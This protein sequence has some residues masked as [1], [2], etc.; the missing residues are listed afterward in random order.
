MKGQGWNGCQ[1]CHM[2][3]LTDNVT[4]FFARGPRQSTSLDGSFS[5]KDPNDQR[6]FNW[7]A[8][9]DEV[10]DFEGN[11]RGISGGVGAV[12]HTKSTPPQATDQIN[13]ATAGHGGLSGSADK[14][15]D[16]AN[17]AGLAQPCVLSD[18]EEIKLYMQ[19]I[20][21]PRKPSNLD[22]EKVKAGRQIFLADG[23][24]Q[25]CHGGDKWTISTRFYDPSVTTGNALNGVA[26]TPTNGFPAAITPAIDP[27]SR[28]MRFPDGDPA[29]NDQ[30]QCILRPVGTF[31]IGD[32]VAGQLAELRQNMSAAAQG[33]NPNG[34]GFNPP[35]L[36]GVQVG[37][38]YLHGGGATTLE[39]LFS[40]T[41]AQH[42][43]AIAP[44]LF[45]ESDPQERA[46]RVSALV[47]FLLSIDADT[48]TTTIPA[49]GAQGGNFCATQ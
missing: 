38:P 33:N 1:S 41:F 11:T 23:S 21:P 5:K 35:S 19:T 17:P 44:N 4:W 31:G 37:A 42:Y 45:S 12:V 15:A 32:Q 26:W 3:G 36:F 29:A 22:D 43:Q 10:A 18:W 9:V 48:A 46:A 25:G 20:R 28:F 39:S 14:A 2:D 8:I 34:K 24:C 40:N 49:V 13:L 7:T 16:P 30:I 47:H 6:I 27:G